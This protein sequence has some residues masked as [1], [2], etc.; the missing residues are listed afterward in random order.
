MRKLLVAI[1]LFCAATASAAV[2]SHALF[3]R[4]KS[5][6]GEWRGKSTKGWEDNVRVRVIA[7]GSV[8]M[9]TSFDAHP[10]ETMVTMVSLDGN[11]LLLT[12]YCVAK[13]QPRL[14]ATSYDQN[15]GTATFEY[16]DGT[17]LS[18]RDKG[19]MDK[20]VMNFADSDRYRSRWTWYQ[21][22]TER[23]MED[24]EYNRIK[25]GP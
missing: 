11:R 5:L 10:G 20:V 1:L 21:N 25:A 24:I 16:L 17:G 2:D 23:W 15:A 3:E 6:E 18:S 14:V 8:V 22:G 9:F 13:N 12:H 19:H 4:I 7:G